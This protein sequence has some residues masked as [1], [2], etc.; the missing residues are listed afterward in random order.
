MET[1][2]FTPPSLI[3]VVRSDKYGQQSRMVV[4]TED[5][6]S[7]K[8]IEECPIICMHQD[9]VFETKEQSEFNLTISHYVFWMNEE[10]SALVLGY[11]SLYNHSYSPNAE[12]SF[13][14]YDLWRLVTTRD[15]KA[16]E[17][18]TIHYQQ[19]THESVQFYQEN[20]Q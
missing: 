7:G 11:G 6:R 15:I 10:Y 13:P 3:K 4:A 12:Y 1:Q 19:Y 16:G 9:E 20:P 14:S 5:I 18:I 8:I 2:E 17:E